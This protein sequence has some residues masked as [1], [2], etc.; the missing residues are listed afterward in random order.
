M[1]GAADAA[2]KRKELCRK[3]GLRDEAEAYRLIAAVPKT[4]IGPLVSKGLNSRTL[5]ELGYEING[6]KR[7]GY[8][9]VNL[10]DLGF[11]VAVREDPDAAPLPSTISGQLAKLS[12]SELIEKG[13]TVF[14]L[15]K[16]GWNVPELERAG[17][18]MEDII[19]AFSAAELRR[20]GCT[21]ADLRRYFRG[22]ELRAAGFQACDMRSA[23]FG[24][25]ELLKFGYNENH[26][27]V[28]G[29]SLQDLIREGISRQ[30]VD[31]T[32]FNQ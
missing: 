30:T 10:H 21:A 17:F 19:Q 3:L 31:K 7:M 1:N 27:R 6:L 29:Y 8:S 9:D 26:V 23:G 16:L 11:P 13:Y 15:K 5:K 2:L 25:R 14:H 4:G 20:C 18:R 32:K 22:D 12:S 24:I 28:A